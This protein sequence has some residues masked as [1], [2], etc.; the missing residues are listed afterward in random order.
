MSESSKI[1]LC[2]GKEIDSENSLELKN[3]WHTK[4]TKKFFGTNQFPEISVSK[5]QLEVLATETVSKGYTVAGVQKKLSLHLSQEKNSRLTIVGYPAGFIL[6]PQTEEFRHLPEMENLVMNLA[7][8]AGIKTVP[9]AL[10]QLYDGFAY[11]TKR[12]DRNATKNGT[13]LFAMEDFCQ[14]SERQTEEK[15]K[16]SYE[17]CAKIIT[18]FSAKPGLDL[19]ELFYRLVFC[20]VTG[21]SDMH[22]KNFSLIESEPKS[23]VYELSAAYDLLPVNLAMPE[24]TEEFALTM[25]GKKSNIKKTDFL[26]FAHSCKISEQAANKMIQRLLSFDEKFKDEV[27]RSFLTEEEK[28]AF[29]DLMTERLGRLKG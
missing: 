28:N 22:L 18:Q 12:I 26:T 1:C 17:R 23:R 7:K 20:F 29:V 2:C 19:A 11:I 13:E 25:N 5:E 16:S 21:N 4:C 27:N 24:D 10:V 3:L 15:Y 14:L 8:I 6:K 9:N